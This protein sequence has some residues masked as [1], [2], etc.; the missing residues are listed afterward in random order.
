MGVTPDYKKQKIELDITRT[1]SVP[2][3]SLMRHDLK[4]VIFE[5][6]DVI[7]LRSTSYRARPIQHRLGYI[8]RVWPCPV[9]DGSQEDTSKILGIIFLK[10]GLKDQNGT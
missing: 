8:R 3:L 4:N 5:I 1:R 9:V 2:F 10:S 6:L 7:F